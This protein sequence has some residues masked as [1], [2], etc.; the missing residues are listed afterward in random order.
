ML[1]TQE[2]VAFIMQVSKS[3]QENYIENQ[4]KKKKK[5]EKKKISFCIT[6]IMNFSKMGVTQ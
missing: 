2:E 1:L 6:R 3:S 4:E 5:G